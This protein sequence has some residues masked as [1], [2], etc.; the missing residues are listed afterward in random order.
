M[1]KILI[2]TT[3]RWIS[4]ARLAIAFRQAG[5]TVEAVGPGASPLHG[6]SAISRMY[7]FQGLKPVRSVQ[8]ALRQSSPD[9]VVPIDD[10]A[11]ICLHRLAGE[12]PAEVKALL[13]ASL[14]RVESYSILES[15]E[16]FLQAAAEEGVLTPES[17]T[18]ESDGDVA[19][20]VAAHG[21]P[22]V[23]K[24]DGTSGGEGVKI[25]ANE[26]EALRAYRQLRA[27]LSIAV[28]AK[29]TGI[30]KDLNHVLPWLLRKQRRVSAQ[31]FIDGRDANIAVACWQGEVLASI[32][33]KVIQAV[34]PKGPAAV[35]Q[36]I[37]EEEAGKAMLDAARRVVKRLGLS[38]L[39]GMDFMI[40][41]ATG[42]PWLIEINARATQTCH[43][44]S[45]AGS[46]LVGELVEKITGGGMRKQADGIQ[47]ERTE[48]EQRSLRQCGDSKGR[49]I[50]LF[51]PAWQIDAG[52]EALRDAYFDL[53]AGEPGLIRAGLAE[54]RFSVGR[55]LRFLTGQPHR[56]D[57]RLAAGRK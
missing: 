25:V 16:L 18:L 53:P 1:A 23:L 33:A 10:L 2:A 14:G 22:A 30:D 4:A 47:A 17:A 57:P 15:R 21:L 39:C 38:G 11:G 40:E 28:V 45:E 50:A 35:I 36:L 27:P 44:V 6:L 51:P 52:S 56:S 26:A 8:G 37:G 20:W 43:L 5:C 7:P 41:R 19:A 49:T 9:L 42:R 54:D 29:R 32:S 31:S 12:G 34:R 13:A 46:D 24:A 3:C 55:R 48:A